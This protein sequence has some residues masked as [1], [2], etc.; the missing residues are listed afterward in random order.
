MSKIE[1]PCKNCIV[2]GVCNLCNEGCYKL[3]NLDNKFIT[4]NLNNDICPDCKNK[5]IFK[6]NSK[7]IMYKNN[8]MAGYILCSNCDHI[9]KF[10]KKV[11]N[12]L[13]DYIEFKGRS[14]IFDY[15]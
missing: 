15:K 14:F 13:T 4:K 7:S 6:D 8:I 12:E 11:S 2:F 10:H 5:L 3:K 9:F 1:Y